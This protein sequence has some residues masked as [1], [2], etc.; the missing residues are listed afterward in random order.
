M[1][2]VRCEKGH[3]YDSDKFID[4]PHCAP[5]EDDRKVTMA[6]RENGVSAEKGEDTVVELQS[7]DTQTMSLKDAVVSVQETMSLDDDD[8][9][10]KTVRYY[11]NAIGTEP[12][13]G[14]LVGL[15]GSVFGK[16]FILKSGRNFIGRGKNM[17]IVLE[18]DNSVSR[19]K[20][21]IVVYEPKSKIF[22]AQPGESRELFYLND[23][24][25]LNNEQL[26]KND[27]LLVGETKLMLIPCC[28][29]KFCWEDAHNEK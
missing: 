4:C 27:V 9:M 1:N 14:W 11:D 22:I 8:D 18:G 2:L 26:E 29:E 16:S 28:D 25:V 20:H 24:V 3:F 13:V 7:T 5:E 10:G 17:D 19:D 12:V 6:Y 21:A 15:T 23:K